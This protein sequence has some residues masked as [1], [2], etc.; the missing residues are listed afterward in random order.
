MHNVKT[1]IISLSKLS[2]SHA[3]MLGILAIVCVPLSENFY[4]QECETIPYIQ[5]N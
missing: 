1:M 3:A 4:T 5:S 2:V